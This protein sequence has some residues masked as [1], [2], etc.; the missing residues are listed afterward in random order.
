MIYLFSRKG[1]KTQKE[2]VKLNLKIRLQ[3]YRN[4]TRLQNLE[5]KV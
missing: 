4:L 3:S 5:L 2:S 1:A